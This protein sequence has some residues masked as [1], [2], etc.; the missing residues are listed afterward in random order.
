M[1]LASGET[2]DSTGKPVGAD[3]RRKKNSFPVVHAMAN[4]TG[5]DAETLEYVYGKDE[6]SDEDVD[7]V[8]DVMQRLGT[9]RHG[10]GPDGAPGD[11][12]TGRPGA[13]GDGSRRQAPG[14]GIGAF[15]SGKR[16]LNGARWAHH[17]GMLQGTL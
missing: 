5:A 13:G 6:P 7:A 15:P 16:A 1:S 8:L 3:V 10:R 9:K 2:P 17:Q 11:A 12:G 14:R 4:A